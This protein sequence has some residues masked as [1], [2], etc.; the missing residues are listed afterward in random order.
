[1]AD[2]QPLESRH[3]LGLVGAG[4]REQVPVISRFSPDDLGQ[5]DCSLARTLVPVAR[6]ENREQ[7]PNL[8]EDLGC[9]R[10]WRQAGSA[11]A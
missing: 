6:L 8:V 1:M 3:E 2:A 4:M 10:P 5:T 9:D 7:R 11:P